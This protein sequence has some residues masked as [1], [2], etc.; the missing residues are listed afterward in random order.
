MTELWVRELL[1]E[2][3]GPVW[4]VRKEARRWPYPIPRRGAGD[5]A[6]QKRQRRKVLLELDAPAAEDVPGK[7]AA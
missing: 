7:A 2:R 6:G 4:M 3:F 1:D 5:T